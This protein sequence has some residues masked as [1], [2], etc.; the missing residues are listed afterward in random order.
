MKITL[1][2]VIL[3]GVF[4]IGVS[5]S[6]KIIIRGPEMTTASVRTYFRQQKLRAAAKQRSRINHI[7]KAYL[8]SD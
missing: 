6:K 2:I 1:I 5:H 4:A 3:S 7:L 8:Q